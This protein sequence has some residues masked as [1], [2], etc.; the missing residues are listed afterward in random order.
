MGQE[1]QQK[2]MYKTHHYFHI[3]VMGTGFTIDTA[4]RVSRF[5][6]A[7]V[8]SL[9]DDLLIERIRKHYCGVYKLPY[10]PITSSQPDPRAR[11]ITAYLDMVHDVVQLQ[12]A[13]L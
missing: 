8:V 1:I 6:I 7:S 9:V 12:I 2:S 11:R 5:G 13:Q 4:L 10:E 3:P